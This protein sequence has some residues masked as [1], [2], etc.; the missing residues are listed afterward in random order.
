MNLGM[1]SSVLFQVHLTYLRAQ[2]EKPHRRTESRISVGASTVLIVLIYYETAGPS[3]CHD[4]TVI[5]TLLKYRRPRSS[6]S[7]NTTLDGLQ[8]SG[9]QSPY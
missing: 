3:H 8:A 6:Q 2:V 4:D 7:H 9:T 5:D 1:M